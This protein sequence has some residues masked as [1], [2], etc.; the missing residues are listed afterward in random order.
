MSF[1]WFTL[2]T[3]IALPVHFLQCT[4]LSKRL[5]CYYSVIPLFFCVAYIFWRF[6]KQLSTHLKGIWPWPWGTA[7]LV[8]LR[9]SWLWDPTQLHNAS[10]VEVLADPGFGP[11]TVTSLTYKNVSTRK[12]RFLLIVF[13][14]TNDMLLGW[15]RKTVVSWHYKYSISPTLP[16]VVF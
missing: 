8:T 11:S 13:M 15:I 10:V 1:T 7:P 14:I 4:A 2:T 6:L 9:C 12:F 16:L 5:T 3:N